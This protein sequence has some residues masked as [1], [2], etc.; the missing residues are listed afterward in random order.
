MCFYRQHNGKWKLMHLILQLTQER[1]HCLLHSHM[2]IRQ[3][4]QGTDM[5]FYRRQNGKWKVMHIILFIE[6][7]QDRY[8]CLLHPDMLSQIK[9][10]QHQNRRGKGKELDRNKKNKT[11]IQKIQDTQQLLLH[12][13]SKQVKEYMGNDQE[14]N[15]QFFNNEGFCQLVLISVK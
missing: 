5:F 14:S 13:K 1:Y 10:Q 7:T 9:I 15:I 3:Q 2:L 4:P 12:L 8:H 11:D 6:L